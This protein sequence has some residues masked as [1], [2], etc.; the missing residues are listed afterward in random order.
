MCLFNTPLS[1][2]TA[3]GGSGCCLKFSRISLNVPASSV[4]IPPLGFA[5]PAGSPEGGFLVTVPV[6]GS[7]SFLPGIE[8]VMALAFLALRLA[9]FSF[10]A[11]KIRPALSFPCFLEKLLRT[12]WALSFSP[13]LSRDSIIRA[14]FFMSVS[15]AIVLSI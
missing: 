1:P 2:I 12:C 4:S 13:F 14:V 5:E 9:C 10:K 15:W 6:S 7:A 3:T 8:A 11:A